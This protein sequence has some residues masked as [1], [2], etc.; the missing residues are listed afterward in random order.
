MDTLSYI[1]TL[2]SGISWTIVYLAIIYRGFNDETYGMPFLALAFN[3]TW[4]FIFSFVA[5]GS[6]SLQ[7]VINMTW[8]FFDLVILYT[9]FRYGR[10]EFPESV[11]QKW[12]GPWSWLAIAVGFVTQYFAA[13]EFPSLFGPTYSALIGNLVMSI[14]FIDMLV[15]RAGVEGQ[16]MGVAIF[17]WLGTTAA[18]ISLH[19]QTNSNLVLVLGIVIFV[20]D[21]I[22][23]G[24][25]YQKF[26]SLGLHP[27]TRQ[28]AR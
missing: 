1:L 7:V 3:L 23:V 6:L 8:F 20:F 28:P 9:Y 27:F 10:K 26:R 12:F 17:K 22:Y 21:L 4:D 24:M 15:R 18:A 19:Q 2:I 13:L 16:S 25:L 5:G 11:G 14:L